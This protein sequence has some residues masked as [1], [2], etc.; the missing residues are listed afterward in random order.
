ML[1][2]ANR[3]TGAARINASLRTFAKPGTWFA[4]MWAMLVGCVASGNAHWTVPSVGRVLLGMILAG[5]LLCAFSQIANDW[6]DREVDRINEPER[7]TAANLLAPGTVLAIALSL[8][9][10]ALGLA[11]ALGTNVLYLSVGGLALALAYSAPPLRLKAHNGWLANAACAFAY[12]GFAWVAGAA[13]F[14]HVTTGTLVLATLYSLGSHGLMTLNDF[15]SYEGDRRLGLRSLPVMLGLGGALR[16][17]FVFID[18][19]QTLAIA[20][21]LYH[22]M[23][24]AGAVML[25]LF[26]VQIPM[27]RKL[28]TDPKGLAPWYCASA[29][30]PFVWGM[31]VSALALRSGG[32]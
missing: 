10:A 13:I 16:A 15:K 1:P 11:A 20:Y 22:R 9:L 8:A 23:W 7:P 3:R 18:L 19:F 25:L 26:I 6:F 5:P 17:A 31:L 12:E 2:F 32:F 28:A 4:P 27:Q 14:G 21:V 29:I 24:L 30:P